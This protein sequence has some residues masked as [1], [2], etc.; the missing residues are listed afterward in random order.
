MEETHTTL[1]VLGTCYSYTSFSSCEC[2]EI[3]LRSAS[4]GQKMTRTYCLSKH[5][6]VYHI[7]LLLKNNHTGNQN[8]WNSRHDMEQILLFSLQFPIYQ[9]LPYVLIT[10]VETMLAVSNPE[11]A[12]PEL[13][14]AKRR[15]HARNPCFSKGIVTLLKSAERYDK[16]MG[17]EKQ[18]LSY[19][20]F[21]IRKIKVNCLSCR[22]IIK[23]HMMLW[24]ASCLSYFTILKLSLWRTKIAF[25]NRTN[26]SCMCI[27]IFSLIKIRFA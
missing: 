12:N 6:K 19:M 13:A 5:L 15:S 10:V 22:Q 14:W 3:L 25:S 23:T 20:T 1:I 8:Y 21:V 27:Y 4:E 2:V 7:S 18:G 11:L 24:V 17:K 9:F 16:R 26:V